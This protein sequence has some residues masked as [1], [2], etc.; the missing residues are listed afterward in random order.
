L[1]SCDDGKIDGIK[2]DPLFGK[3]DGIREGRGLGII[4]DL[5]DGT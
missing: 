5:A 4:G 1:N 3:N 2:D